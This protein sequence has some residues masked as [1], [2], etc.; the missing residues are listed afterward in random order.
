VSQQDISRATVERLSAELTAVTD[1]AVAAG[2]ADQIRLHS[3]LAGPEPVESPELPT[4]EPPES[5]P[6][7][8]A[9]G[10]G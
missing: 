6:A 8:A 5:T 2:I 1:P 3:E 10:K 7:K 4:V 9:R